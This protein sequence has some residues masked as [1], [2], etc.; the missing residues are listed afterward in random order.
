MPSDDGPGGSLVG[1]SELATYIQAGQPMLYGML[2]IHNPGPVD[3]TIEAIRVLPPV[4][5]IVLDRVAIAEPAFVANGEIAWAPV[6]EGIGMQRIDDE[7]QPLPVIV[8]PTGDLHDRDAAAVLILH[9]L[10]PGDATFD[11]IAIDYR[12]GPFTFTSIQNVGLRACFAP[13]PAGAHCT[14][15]SGAHP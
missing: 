3:I 7:T 1:N 10:E 4:G 9:G 13:L 11:R 12:I 5:N 14:D 8:H 2:T 6:S 15:W